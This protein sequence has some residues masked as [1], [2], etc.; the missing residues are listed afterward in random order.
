MLKF[1]GL[2]FSPEVVI[3]ELSGGMPPGANWK[4]WYDFLVKLVLGSRDCICGEYTRRLRLK[5]AVSLYTAFQ[6]H[7]K[8]IYAKL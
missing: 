5:K 4:T 2:S 6:L 7:G 8:K 1:D 3:G